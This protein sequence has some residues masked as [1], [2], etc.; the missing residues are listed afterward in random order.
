MKLK[1][2]DEM[3]KSMDATSAELDKA[4]E[5]PSFRA[6][7]DAAKAQYAARE[8]VEGLLC[9]ARSSIEAFRRSYHRDFVVSVTIDDAA[10]RP[11][12]FSSREL[13]FA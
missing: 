2:T 5:D 11:T 12:E 9:T 6:E 8:L 13:A 4:M 3:R 7:V 10:F 1:I